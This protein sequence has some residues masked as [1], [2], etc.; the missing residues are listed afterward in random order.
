MRILS[1]V[2]LFMTFSPLVAQQNWTTYYEKH[3]FNGTPR[4]DETIAFC[5][6]LAANSSFIAIDTIGTSPQGRP[7]VMLIID[8]NEH[9]TPQL[10]ISSGNA[11]LLVQSAIH[12]G[13]PD[14]K[15]AMFQILRD[16]VVDKK[17]IN[18]LNHVTVL[19]IPILN[20]DGH[21]R[22]SPYSRINQNGP[23]AMGWRTN[24]QN[25]NL[26]RDYLKAESPEIQAWISTFNRWLPDFF[27]DCHTTDGADYQYPITQSM[28]T[29]GNM[30]TSLTSWQR[31]FYLAEAEKKMEKAGFP[32]F[33]YVSYRNW[34]D[35]R[36]GLYVSVALP[37]LSEG[38]TALQNRPGLLIETHMLKP[39]KIRVESTQKLILSTMEIL[40]KEYT[41]LKKLNTKAD[42]FCAS[43]NFREKPLALEFSTDF[44]DSVF[45]EF[46]G[47]SYNKITSDLSG[48]DWFKYSSTPE[49]FNLPMFKTILPSY[50]VQLPEAYVIPPEWNGVIEKLKLH[51]IE[52][53]TLAEPTAIKVNQY[54]LNNYSWERNPMEGR[55]VMSKVELD[56]FTDIVDFPAGS[57]IVSMNQRT[58]RVIANIL[59]PKAPDSY[60]YWGF[61]DAITEQKEYAE[62]YAMETIARDMLAN[63]KELALKFN[64]WKEENPRL[65]ASPY[66]ILNWFYRQSPWWDQKKDLY[67]VGR[68]MNKVDNPFTE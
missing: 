41:Q 17:D 51:G 64:S 65:S 27:I 26:N 57:V 52:Y 60:V 59:E 58:A 18:L 32:M 14:G 29:F 43:E 6:Q 5:Q 11:V 40:D 49:T 28:E 1:I 62:S 15:D 7:I 4:Y 45:V 39:Y 10:V 44:S 46:K 34:H 42:A 38:Y 2:F 35:P 19:W 48:G 21:E 54:R 63:N 50:S 68:I 37:R 55:H 61:F 67:P 8:K 24:A 20:V 16:M 9:F 56:E 31:D 13:E 36:S 25:L 3:G 30:D 47:V 53:Q 23:E 33:Q 22:Y 12:A 66:A